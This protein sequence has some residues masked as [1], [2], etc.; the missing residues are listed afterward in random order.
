MV[1]T[2]II[3]I[4]NYKVDDNGSQQDQLNESQIFNLVQANSQKYIEILFVIAKDMAICQMQVQN[5]NAFI[6]F[7]T[8]SHDQGGPGIIDPQVIQ[9]PH[10]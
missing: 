6:R 5:I 10:F 1:D 2:T 3:W 8:S 9:S 7:M 4:E